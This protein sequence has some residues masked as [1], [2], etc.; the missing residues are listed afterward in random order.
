[1]NV[2]LIIGGS[3]EIPHKEIEYCKVTDIVPT[4]LHFIGKKPHK[5]VVG[6]NLI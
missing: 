2:P 4:L 6:R 5:S 1:M 3:L